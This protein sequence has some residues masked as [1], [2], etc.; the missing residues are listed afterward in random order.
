[1]PRHSRPPDGFASTGLLALA[2][3]ALRRRDP[4]LVPPGIEI[5]SPL[6]R[7]TV[8]SGLKHRILKHALAAGGPGPILAIGAALRLADGPTPAVLMASQTPHG[9]VEK[10][11]RLERYHHTGNRCAIETDRCGMKVRRFSVPPAPSPGL[12]ETLLVAGVLA[13]LADLTGARD[14]WVD[15]G[16]ERRPLAELHLI[17]RV[18]AG[19]TEF[20]I[21]W[22]GVDLRPEVQPPIPGDPAARLGA[23]LA[24][25]TGR[26]WR[27]GD[28]ALSL[29]MSPRALQRA[30]K[31]AD[32]GFAR[33]LRKARVTEAG[34]LLR[35][36]AAGLAEIGYCCGYADQAHFQ[37]DFRRVTNMTPGEYRAIAGG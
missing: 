37:R 10:W 4:D 26:T 14:T 28:A 13:H 1:M 29:G 17:T 11:L 5:P 31:N 22:R 8:D 6:D 21:G 25:D 16:G 34:R 2:V 23:L 12:P 3:S 18:H 33:L 9:M 27:L 24:A 36:D 7:A 35:A 19:L 30:L 32:T 20:R 15:L